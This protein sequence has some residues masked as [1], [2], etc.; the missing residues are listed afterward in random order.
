MT[1]TQ[2]AP[3]SPAAP[4]RGRRDLKPLAALWPFIDAHRGDAILAGVFMLVSSASTIGLTFAL[5]R[6]ADGGLSTHSIWRSW[7][8]W[9]AGP[10]RWPRATP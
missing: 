10:C 9:W 8:P 1:T 6:M 5:R 4:P 3:E 7:R 2:A